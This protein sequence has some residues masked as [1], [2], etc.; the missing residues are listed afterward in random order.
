M[1][2]GDDFTLLGYE[3]DLDAVTKEM[4][5]WYDLKARATLGGEPGDDVAVTILNRLVTWTNGKLTYEADPKHAQLVCQAEGL[6][7]GSKGLTCPL[8]KVTLEEA[9][10]EGKC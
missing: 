7:P 8:V 1:V 9:L 6:D 5:S 4:K 3:H 2:H 10:D